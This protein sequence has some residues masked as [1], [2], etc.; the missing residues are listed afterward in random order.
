LPDAHLVE[1]YCTCPPA[2]AAARF[3]A[4]RRHPGHHDQ[5]HT[6]EDVLD[7]FTRLD[8]EGPLHIG[9]LIH[10]DT[11][12]DIDPGSVAAAIHHHLNP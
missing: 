5:R 6:T 4:R 1:V 7:Q 12:D 2:V 11:S 10:A 9:H 3:Q 8:A